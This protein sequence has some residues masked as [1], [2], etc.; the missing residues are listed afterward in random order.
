MSFRLFLC[1]DK[2]KKETELQL[3]KLCWYINFGYAGMPEP[4]YRFYEKYVN[5]STE[6]WLSCMEKMG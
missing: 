5:M 1:A 4:E 3:K 2:R 6:S